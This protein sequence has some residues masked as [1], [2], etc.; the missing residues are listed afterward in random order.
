M[1]DLI[2]TTKL[3]TRFFDLDMFNK[4]TNGGVP[5]K[6]LNVILAG[7][8]VGKSLFMCHHAT[9]CYSANLNVLYITCEMAEQR[10]QRDR[11]EP[12]GCHDG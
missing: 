7:T 11:C 3:N 5:N 2:F 8:G 10:M 1:S 12:D 4:I 6:T 9:N